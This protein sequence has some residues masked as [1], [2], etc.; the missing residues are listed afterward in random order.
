MEL[1]PRQEAVT[2]TWLR[3]ERVL[4]RRS[5][6][7]V[8]LSPPTSDELLLLEGTGVLTWELLAE[9]IAE[10]ELAAEMAT[11]FGVDPREVRA[12]LEPFLSQLQE[13]GVVRR[14]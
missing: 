1:R 5:G 8:I 12:Q 2:A 7:T 10:S 9:P 4:W 3:D 11:R 14:A 6:A 13:H